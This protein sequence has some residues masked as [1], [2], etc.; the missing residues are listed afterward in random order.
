MTLLTRTGH[1][2][3]KISKL[4]RLC[5]AC[6]VDGGCNDKSPLCLRIRAEAERELKR[7]H[8]ADFVS[9]K[10]LRLLQS[11]PAGR[12]AIMQAARADG[13][14]E[15]TVRRMLWRLKRLGLVDST[16][17]PGAVPEQA[18]HIYALRIAIS[19]STASK[20]TGTNGDSA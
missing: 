9:S 17:G 10:I 20:P 7:M 5:F 19:L 1:S 3:Y 8:T 18:P 14:T 11:G 12:A 6:E 13:A 16:P 2:H 4:D 15:K